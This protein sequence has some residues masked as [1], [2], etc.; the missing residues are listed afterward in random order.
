MSGVLPA[1]LTPHISDL[2]LARRVAAE[3]SRRQGYPMDRMY[4]AGQNDDD[5]D[6]QS[7]LL[8]IQLSRRLESV[9]A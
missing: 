7:A 6:V 3:V 1:E 5:A 2:E 8:A 4:L 9:A